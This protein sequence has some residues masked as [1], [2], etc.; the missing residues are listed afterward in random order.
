MM[1]GQTNQADLAKI[2]C[3]CRESHQSGAR[4]H[5]LTRLSFQFPDYRTD[6]LADGRS[7]PDRNRC[8][9]RPGHLAG[10]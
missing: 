2:V 3:C 8:R 10:F 7:E 1:S 4:Q 5:I 9:L 6:Y